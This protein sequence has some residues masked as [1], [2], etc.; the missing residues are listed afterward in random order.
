M[1][2]YWVAL[3]NAG[4]LMHCWDRNGTNLAWGARR[5]SMDAY[6]RHELGAEQTGYR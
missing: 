5:V 6:E 3:D 1:K 4:D 2:G